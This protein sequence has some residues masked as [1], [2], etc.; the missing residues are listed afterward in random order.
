MSGSVRLKTGV[1]MTRRVTKMEGTVTMKR[2]TMCRV[3]MAG[4]VLL[5]M[6]W[7]VGRAGALGVVR[8]D[9]HFSVREYNLFH[10]V[11]HPLQHE[12]LPQRD[13]KRI[14]ARAG[15]LVA[16]GRAI[17]RLGT[18]AGVGDREAFARE[19]KAFAR[20]LEVFRRDARKGTEARL[21]ASYNAVHDSFEMLASMLP[22]K[23]AKV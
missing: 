20:A 12:A 17:V 9:E 11:L 18:P 23:T 4:C 5:L 14:R 13:F 6:G 21:E 2:A 7:Q 8:A 1:V 3:L 10:D 22:V 16:R 15:E 19:L